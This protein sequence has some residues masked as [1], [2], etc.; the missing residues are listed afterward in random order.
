[1]EDYDAKLDLAEALLCGL[2]MLLMLPVGA[3][4]VAVM[5]G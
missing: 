2:A 5:G 1:M 3:I 4:L